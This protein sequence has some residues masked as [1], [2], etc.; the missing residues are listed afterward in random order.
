MPPLIQGHLEHSG[1]WGTAEVNTLT[2]R[3]QCSQQTVSYSRDEQAA[4]TQKPYRSPCKGPLGTRTFKI[5]DLT[6]S[7]ITQKTRLCMSLS[8]G[9]FLR[10]G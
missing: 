6:G 8:L 4:V 3:L 7:R 2:L 1:G 5:V 9:S 10:L